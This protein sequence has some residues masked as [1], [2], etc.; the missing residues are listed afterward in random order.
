MVPDTVHRGR[1]SY[2]SIMLPFGDRI[3]Y[4][5][6]VQRCIW[7]HVGVG[8]GVFVVVVILVFV[9]H[10]ALQGCYYLVAVV[11]VVLDVG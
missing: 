1:I 11:V 9:S 8:L 3:W 7:M 4:G 10:R 5:R 2:D 6:L